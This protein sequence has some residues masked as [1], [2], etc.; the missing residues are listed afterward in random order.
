MGTAIAS[1]IWTI[2]I[3]ALC[4]TNN[5]TLFLQGKVAGCRDGFPAGRDDG[6]SGMVADNS[7]ACGESST[8][9]PANSFAAGKYAGCVD[10]YREGFATGT[11]ALVTDPS[12]QPPLCPANVRN[13]ATDP[14]KGQYMLGCVDGFER[15]KAGP[16]SSLPTWCV[17]DPYNEFSPK[18]IA[19]CQ[20]GFNAAKALTP[21]TPSTPS[22]GNTS[23]YGDHNLI[24]RFAGLTSYDDPIQKYIT[25]VYRWSVGFAA[26]LAV[27]QIVF[28][29]ILYVL[30]AGSLYS[31]EE[32]TGKMRNA[33]VGL[34]LLLSI[35]LILNLINPSLTIINPD[36]YT[37]AGPLP[38]TH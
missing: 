33:V 23:A 17:P 20:A 5:T 30:A 11:L 19:G 25:A 16:G 37:P 24:V 26:L 34:L 9:R 8:P 18:F 4:G 29:G 27:F 15:G 6:F 22:G 1:S 7:V 13:S 12:T 36:L 10:K 14:D 32:A 21:N 3:N 31:Q 38:P 35:T 2:D 28:G